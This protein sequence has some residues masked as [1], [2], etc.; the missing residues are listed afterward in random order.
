L[1]AA[2]VGADVDFHIHVDCSAGAGG[3][4]SKVLEVVQT[5]DTNANSRLLRQRRE[6]RQ[7]PSA[8]DRSR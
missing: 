6:T 5:V 2:A 7:F 3:C 1:N 4:A 8:Y